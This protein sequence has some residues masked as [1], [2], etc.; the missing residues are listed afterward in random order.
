MKWGHYYCKVKELLRRYGYDVLIVDL[1]TG[2]E[3]GSREEIYQDA[4]MVQSLAR[5]RKLI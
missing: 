5:R 1:E 2:L 4:L 3:W